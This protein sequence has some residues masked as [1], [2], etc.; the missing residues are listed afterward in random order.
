MTTSRINV[1]MRVAAILFQNPTYSIRAGASG[2]LDEL[3]AKIVALQQ[4]NQ[5]SRRGF[6]SIEHGLAVLE[7]S[8]YDELEQRRVR[9]RVALDPVEHDH[10]LDLDPVDEDRAEHLDAVGLGRVV[11]GDQAADD[12]SRAKIHQ[13]QQRV[14]DL[15]ADVLEVDI[16]DFRARRL[17]IVVQV[18]G[19]VVDA[20]I[21]AER[22]HVLAFLRPAGDS[23]RTAAPGFRQL[24]DD[25][26]DRA[27]GRGYDD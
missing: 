27:G 6:D 12:D 18:A 11:L 15:A 22:A 5:A 14:E 8:C 21:E 17:Q 2:E 4:A 16:D 26:A 9:F 3:L 24:A 23:D 7:L 10:P 25:H 1:S 20:R 13:A 19:L